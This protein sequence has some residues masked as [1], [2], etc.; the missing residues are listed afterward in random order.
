MLQIVAD[1]RC[2]V[3]SQVHA[4]KEKS[5]FSVARKPPQALI[6]QPANGA[7]LTPGYP[8]TLWGLGLDPEGGALG[9]AALSW[10]DSVS[11]TRGTGAEIELPNGLAS[12]RH[13]LTLT[14]TDGDGMTS[15][16]SVTVYVGRLSRIWLPLVRKGFQ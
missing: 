16:D 6:V 3:K 11:G 13:M 7:V 4:A 9:N 15:A 10:S 1:C 2:L 8:L 14:V 12:G 5:H